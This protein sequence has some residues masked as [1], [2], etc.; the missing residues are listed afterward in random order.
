MCRR[1]ALVRADVSEDRIDSIF[2]VK[3]IE[4]LRIRRVLQLQN[5]ANVL[6]VRL[7]FSP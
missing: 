5:T 1:V 7:L 4:E 6:L 3:I 2:M